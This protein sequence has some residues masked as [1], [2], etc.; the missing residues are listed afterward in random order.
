[1]LARQVSELLNYKKLEAEY[2]GVKAEMENAGLDATALERESVI[3]KELKK[4]ANKRSSKQSEADVS[5]GSFAAIEENMKKA[6][7]RLRSAEFDDIDARYLTQMTEAQSIEIACSDLEKYHKVRLFLIIRSPAHPSTLSHSALFALRSSFPQA[8]ERTLLSFHAAKMA[9]INKTIKELWQKTYRGV[10]IDYIQIKAD[11]ETTSTRSSY[12]YRVVMFVGG[13]E[14][15]M[16]GRCSAGQKILSC[17][18]IRLALAENFCLNCG[19]L[20]LDEPT[21]NLDAENSASLAEA[22][23]S[24]MVSRKDYESFQLI[25]ITHDEEFAMR[26]GTR[27]NVEFLWRISKDENQHSRIRREPIS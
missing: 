27:D 8:L 25:V 24:L 15:D 26:L 9:D 2:E 10:D 20:A 21:T 12:N 23:K 14:L 3:D 1:V 18:I 22:L 5:A 6:Q 17:L 11:T 13:A 7:D 16:R 4:L 19:V